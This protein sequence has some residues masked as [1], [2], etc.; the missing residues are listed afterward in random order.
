MDLRIIEEKLS[1]IFGQKVYYD[2]ET[3]KFMGTSIEGEFYIT[4]NKME[5]YSDFN[6]YLTI[7]L[8]ISELEIIREAITYCK[9]QK[10]V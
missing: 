9:S 10:E 2:E 8:N 5:I 6:E 3:N 7:S 4:K 1:N